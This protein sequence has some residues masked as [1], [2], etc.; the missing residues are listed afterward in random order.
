MADLAAVVAAA[1]K[2]AV[3]AAAAAIQEEEEEEETV[4]TMA[5]LAAPAVLTSMPRSREPVS[6]VQVTRG[7]DSLRSA[8]RRSPW[9][10]SPVQFCW[11]W[12]DWR[13]SAF[14]VG[15]GLLEVPANLSF[16]KKHPAFRRV[17]FFAGNRQRISGPKT[18]SDLGVSRFGNS[19]PLSKGIFH[20]RG[21]FEAA[22]W[23]RN[24]TVFSEPRAA[25]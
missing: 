8:P 12:L 21:S 4:S 23:S 22:A 24:H 3:A 25:I 7:M 2:V 9:L 14:S 15:A 6:S 19:K 13:E 1:G 10:P 11:C 5:I 20:H 18:C 16:W 17:F